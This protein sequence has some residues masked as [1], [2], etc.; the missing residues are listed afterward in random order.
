MEQKS[1]E[2]F[3]ICRYSTQKGGLNMLAVFLDDF[4]M[5]NG[6]PTKMETE[7]KYLH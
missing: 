7:Q 1:K 4:F 6:N 2:S 3:Y 5:R